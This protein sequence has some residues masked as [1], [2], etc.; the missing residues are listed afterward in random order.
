MEKCLVLLVVGWSP[1]SR[2]TCSSGICASAHRYI[3]TNLCRS[4]GVRFHWP[5][6]VLIIPSGAAA[7]PSPSPSPS[8]SLSHFCF[9]AKWETDIYSFYFEK[10]SCVPFLPEGLSQQ[11][12]RRGWRRRSPWRTGSSPSGSGARPPGPPV[13]PGPGREGH[14]PGD[15]EAE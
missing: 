8:P 1:L 6:I 2:S 13:A 3:V 11:A 5:D 4:L 7:S 9:S 15:G 12:V 14:G 10:S